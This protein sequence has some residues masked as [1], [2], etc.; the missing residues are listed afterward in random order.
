MPQRCI[1][2]FQP[3]ACLEIIDGFSV[4]LLIYT[5]QPSDLITV[6]H[7]RV[8]ADGTAAILLGTPVVLKGE[9]GYCSV[10]IRFRQ[11]RLGVYDLVEI[12][13]GENEII[14]IE[15]STPYR[16]HTVSID[17]SLHRRAK[18]RCNGSTDK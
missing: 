12:L 3:Q 6:Y 15:S 13:D 18:K 1:V 11:I 8:P 4:I 16:H 17:L 9:F 5:C 10:E 7:E 14:I 2:R